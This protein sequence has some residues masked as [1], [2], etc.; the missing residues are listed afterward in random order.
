MGYLGA[1][2]TQVFTHA[3]GANVSLRDV[4]VGKRDY[5]VRVTSRTESARRIFWD[6]EKVSLLSWVLP[7]EKTVDFRLLAEARP[8]A[9]VAGATRVEGG[10]QMEKPE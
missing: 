2:L 4:T 8:V 6:F 9:I 7:R 1:T 5:R 3:R 10:G